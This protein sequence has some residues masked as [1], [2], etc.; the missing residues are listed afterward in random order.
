M[1]SVLK[2]LHLL[3]AGLHR[4]TSIMKMMII[5]MMIIVTT[6]VVIITST[7]YQVIVAVILII[8]LIRQVATI[9]MITIHNSGK[10]SNNQTCRNSA[11]KGDVQRHAEPPK[12][13]FLPTLYKPS[14][15]FIFHVL[16][17]LIFHYWGILLVFIWAPKSFNKCPRPLRP[18]PKA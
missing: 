3:P 18:T 11:K 16:F 7:K 4:V 1:A 10:I 8:V 17:H 13:I 6:E 12:A 5:M 9:V 2:L 15:H 14:F